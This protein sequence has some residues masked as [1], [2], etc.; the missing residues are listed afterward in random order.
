MINGH[1]ETLFCD[2]IRQE[3]G[4]K[5]SLIGV[6]SG[7]LL[8]PEF[9]ATLPKMC[10]W[11]N[12]VML[13]VE[14]PSYLNL[15]VMKGVTSSQEVTIAKRQWVALP[16]IGEDKM[17]TQTKEQIHTVQVALVLSPI[18]F[19]APCILRVRIQTNDGELYGLELKVEQQSTPVAS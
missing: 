13:A 6:Y 3:I 2:D 16:R 10:V 7:V 5:I 1:I 18:E 4:G 12:I 14:L 8:V 15:Y 9:P 17:P 11:I 19:D